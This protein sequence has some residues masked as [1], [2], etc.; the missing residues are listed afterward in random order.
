MNVEIITTGDEILQGVIVDTNT[1]WLS[2]HVH[3]L[4]HEVVRHSSVGDD[5]QKMCSLFREAAG[6]SDAVIVSGGLGPT[7]DDL[8]IEAAAAAF[9][10]QLVKDEGVLQD[11]RGFFERIG[12]TMSPSNEKQAMIPKGSSILTNKVGTAPGVCTTFG[13]TV[14]FFLPGVPKELYQIFNDSV[15][16]WFKEKSDQGNCEI[17]LR[18]FGMPEAT[19]DEKL[20][21]VNLHGTRLSFRVRFPEVLLKVLARSKDYGEA[22]FL[23]NKAAEEIKGRLAAIVYAEGETSLSAV[24][25]GMLRKR[26]MTISVAE[27]CT[28]GLLASTLTDEAG[29]SEYFERGIVSYSNRSKQEVLG[30]TPEILKAN[31]AVSR[32]TAMAMA[33]GIRRISGTTIGIAITGI[34]GPG[35]GIPEKPV[36]TVHIAL[37]APEGTSE[38]EYR[39][40]RGRLWFKQI[41]AWTALDLI[42][43]YLLEAYGGEFRGALL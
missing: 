34:A 43:K 5:L 12:R 13:G 33:E 21:G 20:K 1:A 31:G 3:R 17:I 15:L 4:G 35:G 26:G 6:R 7:A 42:R 39:F 25:G 10:T 32:E 8:T 29:S 16:P 40:D 30:V 11:I 22:K 18:C 37:A 27:S 14:F 2:E 28:G 24:V 38:Y 36:G 9:E 23:A 41:V 19:I